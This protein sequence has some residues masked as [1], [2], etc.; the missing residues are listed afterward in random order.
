MN[1]EKKICKKCLLQ[2]LEKAERQKLETY[3]AAIKDSDKVDNT[4]YQNRLDVCRGCDYLSDAT[5]HACGCYV[6]F[7]AAVKQ[8]KCPYK[9]W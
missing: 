2:D 7:R 4:L 8:G 1:S 3:L 5:C 6:E 9:K